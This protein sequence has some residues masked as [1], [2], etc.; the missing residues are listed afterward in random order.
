VVDGKIIVAP[1]AHAVQLGRLLDG[2][3]GGRRFHIARLGVRRLVDVTFPIE[4]AK[5]TNRGGHQSS[6]RGVASDRSDSGAGKVKGT[7]GYL[8][9]DAR[10]RIAAGQKF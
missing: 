3:G 2:P 6:S 8:N 4:G 9:Q 1:V 10:L 7:T 5:T